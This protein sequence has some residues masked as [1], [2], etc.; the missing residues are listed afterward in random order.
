MKKTLFAFIAIILFS[1]SNKKDPFVYKI[2][3]LGNP[4]L[5]DTRYSDSQ[6]QELR[7]LGFNTIQLN[8]AWGSRPGDEP[9]NLE[10]ILAY[11]CDQPTE[12]QL[13]WFDEMKRR[14]VIAKK[15]GFRTIFHFG[16]PHITHLYN[17]INNQDQIDS[18]TQANSV[19]RPDI[20]SRY[21]Y[22][23]SKLAQDIPE[24]DDI[25]IYNFDQEAW[26][27]NEF[28]ND[29]IDAGISLHKRLPSFLKK[30]R[31]AWSTYRPGGIVWWEPWEMSA[32]QIFSMID[33]LPD[34]N[35]GFMLHSNIGEVELT[36]PVDGWLRCM[37]QF[38]AQKQIPL[39]VETFLSSSNE[40]TEPL[41]HVA[42]PE[43]TY[44]EIK[45]IAALPYVSGIKEYYGIVPDRNDPNLQM[46]GLV[47]YNHEI[48]FDDA[49]NTMIRSFDSETKPLIKKA[50]KNASLGIS[51][52]PWDATWM[53]RAH[54]AGWKMVYHPWKAYNVA[55]K[56]AVSPSW[57]STRRGVFMFVDNEKNLHPWVIED[58]GLR[59]LK[60]SECL[61]KSIQ[62]YDSSLITASD[63]MKAIVSRW[64]NDMLVLSVRCRDQGLHAMETLAAL[65]IRKKLIEKAKVPESFYVRLE[66]LLEE[67]VRNQ[68]RF[69]MPNKWFAPAADKLREYKENPEKWVMNNLLFK[70]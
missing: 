49:I 5:P 69:E 57:I 42:V 12:K 19:L 39:V 16:A 36:R 7:R 4:T 14:A 20:I 52:I 6:L 56:V 22:M 23:V 8:I 25:L 31:D 60:A 62:N 45:A 13:K 3:I 43:L 54:C 70:E 41:M 59:F 64:K 61:D 66:S 58:I 33:S 1:C 51:S 9:L 47:L 48:S 67:D 40:E 32:G 18:A 44:N 21:Q 37:S 35:F 26:L 68:S 15:Y 63:S 34:K 29:S 2:A 11:Q 24:I 65:N 30:I 53:F 38:A 55:G 27:G 10:D 50:W 46:A 28:G 17:V